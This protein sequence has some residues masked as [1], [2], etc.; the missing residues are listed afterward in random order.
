[1]P[2]IVAVRDTVP[3]NRARKVKLGFIM[4]IWPD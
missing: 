3:A 4:M 2:R 1:M